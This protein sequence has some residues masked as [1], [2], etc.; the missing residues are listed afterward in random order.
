MKNPN[1][2]CEHVDLAPSFQDWARSFASELD[3]FEH[4]LAHAQHQVASNRSVLEPIAARDPQVRRLIED[5]GEAAVAYHRAQRDL[6]RYLQD[7]LDE[8]G[9]RTK[10]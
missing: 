10:R 5:I 1:N 2:P 4:G 7:R 3:R 8:S 6:A 9:D